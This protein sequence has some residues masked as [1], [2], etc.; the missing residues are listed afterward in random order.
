MTNKINCGVSSNGIV[1]TDLPI[2]ILREMRNAIDDAI[3][4]DAEAKRRERAARANELE[5][6]LMELL[7]KIADEGY[8]TYIDGDYVSTD[9]EVSVCDEDEDEDEEYDEDEDEDEDD[10]PYYHWPY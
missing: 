8:D 6:D 7:D 1:L 9:A 10:Y 2:E 4:A 5:A 3:K